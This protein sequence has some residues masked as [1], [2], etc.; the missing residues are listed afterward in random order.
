MR[1]TLVVITVLIV[2]P[3]FV[4]RT[5]KTHT[6]V[7]LKPISGLGTTQNRRRT[8][9]SPHIPPPPHDDRPFIVLSETK[10]SKRHIPVWA[11]YSPLLVNS[12]VLGPA[13]INTHTT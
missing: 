4:F 7:H 3:F 1:T 5:T 11:R 2:V 8:P 12:F 9:T 10:L 6:I 13:V